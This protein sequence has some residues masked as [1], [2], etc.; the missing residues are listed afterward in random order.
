VT[1]RLP[2]FPL[3]TVLFPGLVLPL[4]I[5]EERYR[6]LV[7]DLLDAPEGAPRRFGVVAIKVGR[8]VGADGVA[9]LYEVGCTAELHTVEAYSDGRFDIITA[10]GVR[11]RLEG[12]EV[13][14]RSRPYACGEV[15]FLDETAGE[16]AEWLAAEVDALFRGYQHRLRI[17]RG[18]PPAEP[19]GLPGD[20]V[21]LSYLVAASAILD[22]TDKQRLL[23]APDAAARLRLERSLLRRETAILAA[24]PSLPAVDLLRQGVTLN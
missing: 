6:A 14:T 19:A 16:R 7:R 9:A 13:D 11:F 8:E 22:L 20:P 5:F 15:E 1:A 24:L 12:V 2:L 17:L 3:G 10:G 23:S 4:H 21:V 18:E